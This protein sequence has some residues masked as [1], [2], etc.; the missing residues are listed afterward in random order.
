MDET[1][2]NEEIKKL[3][4]TFMGPA[5]V[6]E[7][8]PGVY[9]MYRNIVIEKDGKREVSGKP[10]GPL[11]L[12]RKAKEDEL[13]DMVTETEPGNIIHLHRFHPP[14]T[15]AELEAEAQARLDAVAEVLEETSPDSQ[16]SAP[17]SS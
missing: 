5:Y 12:L 10:I 1:I 14:R 6:L 17:T 7:K 13:V 3:P 16:E 9:A 4:R 2:K 11:F 15:E 8:E